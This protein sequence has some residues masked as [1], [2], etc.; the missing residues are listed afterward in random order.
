MTGDPPLTR[1]LRRW[2]DI[3]I[4]TRMA[5]LF[6]STHQLRTLTSIDDIQ[7]AK[8]YDYPELAPFDLATRRAI[9]AEYRPTI[10]E[11]LFLTSRSS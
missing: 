10:M 3:T 4:S 9:L 11:W 7:K 6:Q 1:P 2:P 8:T 5:E